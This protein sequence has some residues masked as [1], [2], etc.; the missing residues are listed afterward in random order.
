MD[1]LDFLLPIVLLL[2][3]GFAVIFAGRLLR[4]SPMV[5]FIIAGIALGPNGLGLIE[6]TKTTHFLAELGVVFLLFDIGLHLSVKSA[7]NLRRDLFGIAPLQMLI[8][9]V[10]LGFA[11]SV[12]FNTNAEM[13]LLVGL[14]LALSS[15]AVVMQSLADLKLSESPIG[16]STKAVLIFQDLAAIFLL[17]FADTLGGDTTL[18]IVIIETLLKTTLA[19]IAAFLGGQYIITPLLRAVTRFDDSEIFTILSLLIVMLTALATASAG[20]SLT[21]GAFLAGMVLAETPFRALLQ[22]ELRP[23][24]SLLM[25]LFFVSVGMVLKP[26]A[27]MEN[28]PIILA[29]T[30]LLIAVK[31]AVLGALAFIFRRPA[32]HAIQLTFILAQGSEFAFVIFSMI[33]VK[34]GIGIGLTEH[35]ITAVALSMLVTPLLAWIGHRWGIALCAPM[36]ARAENDPSALRQT[37]KQDRAVFIVGMNDIGQTIARAM[38]AHKI[39]YIGIDHNRDRFLSSS[40]AGYIVAFGKSDN[41]RFWNTLGIRKAR[42]L[43][44]CSPNFDVAKALSP[45]VKRLYPSLRRYVAVEDSADGVRYAALGLT[46]HH[47][48]GAPPGLEMACFLLKE[49][50]IDEEKIDEWHESEQN[51]YLEMN[52]QST[53]SAQQPVKDAKTEKYSQSS[54][55]TPSAAE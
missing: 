34:T 12:V 1:A 50:G 42:A 17:I 45:I 16:N 41:I 8:C 29:I 55:P 30:V 51:G 43:V 47:K 13:A 10:I 25:A 44:V 21:L 35:L 4:I 3:T 23:F 24:R 20:L 5:G 37:Q 33:A 14:T 48:H 22:T 18:N 27:I 26:V 49:F 54:G 6:E 38:Q 9:G 28:L 31:G 46:P 52:K 15:T 2:G 32:H 53:I 7:W 40:A 39:R 36:V 11:T 19:F